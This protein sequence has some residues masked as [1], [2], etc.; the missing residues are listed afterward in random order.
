MRASNK[1]VQCERC[2]RKYSSTFNMHR[3]MRSYHGVDV[4]LRR[5]VLLSDGEYKCPMHRRPIRFFRR[6]GL[7]QHLYYMDRE[8][9]QKVLHRHGFSRDLICEPCKEVSRHLYE[10]MRNK[11]H[12]KKLRRKGYC[13]DSNIRRI[14]EMNEGYELEIHNR[15]LQINLEL[16]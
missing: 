5:Q 15:H 2:T 10:F 11:K 7:K 4:H 14:D 16:I 3:H 12:M 6:Q 1:K 9:D 8:D 13:R